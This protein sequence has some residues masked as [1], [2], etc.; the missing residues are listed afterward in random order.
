MPPLDGS[1]LSS[2]VCSEGFLVPR[3]IIRPKP[4]REGHAKLV[5][6][7]AKELRQPSGR[8]MPYVLEEEVPATGL[9]T[10]TVIWDRWKG[11]REE[12][13]SD[14]ILGAYEATEGKKSAD[15][16]AIATGLTP[17]EALA[18]GYLSYKVEPLHK[19]SD[20]LTEA[21]YRGALAEEA[22]RTLL[23]KSS[24]ELRYP[25]AEEAHEA[26]DRLTKALPGSNWGVVEE[27]LAG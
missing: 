2:H 13:R 6:E 14:I 9:R 23:G 3:H 21:D 11:V 20:S 18:L 5:Q 24:K 16:V 26:Y 7:L 1:S 15:S 17:E 27:L 25:R 19:A 10:V 8:R 4:G 22:T 12:D